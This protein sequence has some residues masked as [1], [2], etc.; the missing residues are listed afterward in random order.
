MAENIRVLYVDDSPLDRELV[1]DSLMHD[2]EGFD[3]VEAASRVDF[4]NRLGDGGYDIV[5]SDFNILGFEGLQVLDAVSERLP[6]APVVIVTGTGSEEVAVEAMKRGAADYVIKTPSHVRKLPHTLRTVLEKRRVEREH[7]ESIDRQIRR[8]TALIEINRTIT[9]SHRLDTVLTTLLEHAVAQLGVD[10]ANILLF[11]ENKQLLEFAAGTGS[12][13]EAIRVAQSQ[14]SK[15]YAGEAVLDRRVV[16]V[17]NLLD[18]VQDLTPGSP[19]QRLDPG[20]VVEYFGAPLMAKG[21]LE[22]VMEVFS[23]VPLHVDPEWT[24]FLEM[25]AE[26]AAIAI[27]SAQRIEDLRETNDELA[28][29]YSATIEGWSRALDMR[30]HETEGHTVRVTELTLQLGRILGMSEAELVHV[31]RGALLHDIGKLGVPDRILL[32]PASLDENE[33][34]EMRKH[35]E[36]ANAMISPINYLNPALEIPYCHHEKW[37]GT[38][39]PQ[40]LKGTEI[41]WSARIFAVVDVWDAL[42]SDRPYRSAWSEE[43]ALDYIA[44]QSGMHFDPQVVEAFLR[45][46]AGEAPGV[47]PGR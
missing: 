43:A 2:G 11:D 47:R 45:M 30:D 10:A 14:L 46:L 33:W 25:L 42:R 12:D 17:S 38:G 15:G 28:L 39:Y 6:Q 5:I 44:S 27:D 21:H 3:L 19:V 1:R 23:Q 36:F 35:P 8:L 31:R 18:G 22:G 40:G 37:D 9:G 34:A 41:P 32:K 29:A 13:S 26:Q 20:A 4:E 24:V 16:H 7:D